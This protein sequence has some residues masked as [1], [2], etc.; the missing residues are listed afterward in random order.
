[1]SIKPPHTNELIKLLREE[2]GMGVM[3]CKRAL[4]EAGGDMDKAK[5][6]LSEWGRA[7]ADKRGDRD[8]FEG[9]IYSYIHSG[10]RVGVLLDLR[11]ETDFVARSSDFKKLAAEL[12]LQITAT[13]P[14]S[15]N[16]LLEEGYVRNAGVSV[17][18]LIA[19]VSGKVGEKV[20]L[21]R[22]VR[23]EI[24]EEVC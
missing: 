17:G 5:K 7:R 23:Y 8:A 11:C 10:G 9:I 13:S 1:M 2:T 18:D 20:V 16:A 15:V 24:G 21:E 3:D 22:F 14:E 12:A 4:K 6:L 19:E